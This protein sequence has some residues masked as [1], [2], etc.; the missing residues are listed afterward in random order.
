MAGSSG[1]KRGVRARKLE[2]F[3]RVFKIEREEW[4]GSVCAPASN[5]LG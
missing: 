1:R 3:S 5:L 4:V 2:R